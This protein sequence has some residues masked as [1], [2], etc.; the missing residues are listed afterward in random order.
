[1]VCAQAANGVHAAAR[2]KH[3]QAQILLKIGIQNVP[4]D[5]GA[6]E[7]ACPGYFNWTAV[8]LRR[9]LWLRAAY[10]A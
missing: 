7:A 3:A 2:K 8:T 4:V 9:A 10:S 5:D 1:M 6:N